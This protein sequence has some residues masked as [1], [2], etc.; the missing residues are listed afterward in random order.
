VIDEGAR[1]AHILDAPLAQTTGPV[2]G[3][4][5]WKRRFDHMQQ[6]TG[7]HLLSAVLDDA[8]G[9]KTVSVHF[10]VDSSTL[11]VDAA[12]AD[13]AKLPDAETRANAIVWENRPVQVSFED[14]AAALG[15]RKPSDR[16]GE[17][18]VVTID[19][20][21]RSACGG[22]HVRGTA[23]IGPILLRRTERVKQGTRIEFVCGGRAL[24]RA[25]A[26]FRALSQVAQSLTC[27][28]DEVGG[29]LEAKLTAAREAESMLR[30]AERELDGH[31]AR[32]RYEAAGADARGTRRV[33]ERRAHG[34]LDDIRGLA[35]AVCAMPHAAFIGAIADSG[36]VIVGTSEDSGLEAGAT[37]KRALSAAEGRG[38]GSPRMAQGTVAPARLESVL[39]AI[40]TEWDGAGA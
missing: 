3:V 21:D 32:E 1:I 28:L 26:D 37:L 6:H 16:S 15:L 2:R 19:G 23:E 9:W 36:A 8:F 24:A 29:I 30:K 38:G 13:S 12:A 34:A 31:R 5:D 4:V 18:R 27:S 33:V 11:D 35:H 14:S 22:T 20:I 7:Q 10:G 17:I 25:R 39:R 40:A